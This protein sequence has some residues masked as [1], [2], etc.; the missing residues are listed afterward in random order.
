MMKAVFLDTDSLGPGI[1][2]EPL[3]ELAF[4]WTFYPKTD[5]TQ[6]HSRAQEATVIATNKVRI[7]REI[8]AACPHLKLVCIAATGYNNIDLTAAKELGIK[9]CNVPGYS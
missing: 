6:T 8:M 7:T 4:D 9:V 1:S 2:F 5:K 3:A